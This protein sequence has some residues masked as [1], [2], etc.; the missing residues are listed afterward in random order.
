MVRNA[1]IE[2]SI[3]L[4]GGQQRMNLIYIDDVADVIRR[5]TTDSRASRQTFNV[6][7]DCNISVEEI[8]SKVISLLDIPVQIQREPMRAGE[9]LNFTP[10]LGKLE[11]TLSFLPKTTFD[12]GLS[13]TI[14]WYRARLSRFPLSKGADENCGTSM[15][16]H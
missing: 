11:K 10:D 16:R 9:T 13:R 8:V 12:V 14:E 3:K 1:L 7:S 6:G 4:L 5:C 15:S 2:R